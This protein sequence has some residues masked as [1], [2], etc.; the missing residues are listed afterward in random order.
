MSAVSRSW[1]PRL[2]MATVLAGSLGGC[3]F[4]GDVVAAGAGGASAAA[5][6]NP[7][8]G[9]AIGIGVQAATEAIIKYVMR[10]RQQ[11]EQDAIAKTVGTMDVGESR[12]WKIRHDIPIGN[13]HGTVQVTRL[14]QNPLAVCKEAVFSVIDGHRPDAPRAWYTTTVCRQA[15]RWKW[16]MAEPAVERWGYLQ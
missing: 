15:T 3:K 1:I 8:V 9:V 12:R 13:E 4:A 5:T 16:A 11:A 6:A 7:A 10:K 14:I 2:A